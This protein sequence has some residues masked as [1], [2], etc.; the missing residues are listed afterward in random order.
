M[1]ADE[2]AELRRVVVRLQSVSKK[3]PTSSISRGYGIRFLCTIAA[4]KLPLYSVPD[5][6]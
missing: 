1:T 4:P 2:I 6:V 3:D 5:K